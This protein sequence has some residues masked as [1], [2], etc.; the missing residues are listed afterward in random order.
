VHACL[1]Q[2]ILIPEIFLTSIRTSKCMSITMLGAPNHPQAS[3]ARHR[4]HL[5]NHPFIVW[6]SAIAGKSVTADQPSLPTDPRLAPTML[7]ALPK[8]GPLVP[9]WRYIVTAVYLP[10]RRDFTDMAQLT[11]FSRLTGAQSPGSRQIWS[12]PTDWLFDMP[13]S[14]G[15]LR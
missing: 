13:G 6:T 5:C 4:T 10:P 9:I 1:N 2:F 7:L 11:P 12:S 8:P 15:S 14:Q 3:R